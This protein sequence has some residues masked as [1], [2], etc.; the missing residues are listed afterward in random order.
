MNSLRRYR[1][2]PA[3]LIALLALGVALS[4]TAY[5]ATKINGNNVAIRTLPGKALHKK[6]VGSLEVARKSLSGKHIADG[7]LTGTQMSAGYTNSLKLKCP[8]D[9]AQISGGCIETSSRGAAAFANAAATC[10][11]AGRRLPT[12]GEL[13][14]A[15]GNSGVNLAAGGELSSTAYMNGATQE[16]TIVIS[17]STVAGIPIADGNHAFRCVGPLNNN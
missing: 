10:R 13:A 12:P 4:G 7:G 14:A 5:A 16:V 2:S 15:S 17:S 11:G 9:T 8:G 6:S 1:P 3:M